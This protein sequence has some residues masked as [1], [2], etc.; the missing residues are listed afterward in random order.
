MRHAGL[1]IPEIAPISMAGSAPSAAGIAAEAAPIVPRKES[2]MR[3]LPP[4]AAILAAATLAVAACP[5]PSDAWDTGSVR[6]RAPSRSVVTSERPPDDTVEVHI[7]KLGFGFVEPEDGEAAAVRPEADEIR[8]YTGDYRGLNMLGTGGLLEVSSPH[9][10]GQNHLQ[11]GFNFIDHRFGQQPNRLVAR[12]SSQS[13]NFGILDRLDV[14]FGSTSSYKSTNAATFYNAKFRLTN[15]KRH[16]FAAAMGMRTFDLGSATRKNR[17]DWY[18]TASF[19]M[20]Y[21]ELML[22]ASRDAD[23]TGSWTD[24]FW[25]GGLLFTTDYTDIKYPVGLMIE[26]LQ[27]QNKAF[28]IF[29]FGVRWAFTENAIIDLM[30]KRDI[31]QD[32]FSPAVGG[33]LTF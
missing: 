20:R 2:I 24:L 1:R 21:S 30:M 22:N 3:I 15:P 5:A 32:E 7:N 16:K 17:T 8:E 29:N 13:L 18:G 27:D 23:S 6:R 31:R 19:P 12:Y 10:A 9:T 26:T 14:G 33:T 25:S 11:V 28:N 4:F